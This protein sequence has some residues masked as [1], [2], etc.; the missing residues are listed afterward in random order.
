MPEDPIVEKLDGHEIRVNPAN[1]KFYTYI[2]GQ[3]FEARTLPAVRTRIHA[4]NQ[5]VPAFY[6]DS[7]EGH[8]SSYT[9]HKNQPAMVIRVDED[10]RYQGDMDLIGR[11][12][13][14]YTHTHLY[15]W[16]EQRIAQLRALEEQ[17]NALVAQRERLFEDWPPF[18]KAAFEAAQAAQPQ[19]A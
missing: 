10:R 14:P 4:Q 12:G 16:D 19:E 5:G 17:L 11:N 1:S 3:R 7:Y 2:A 9:T 8:G 18:N 6:R 15:V 13:K